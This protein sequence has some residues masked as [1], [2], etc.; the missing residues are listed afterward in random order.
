MTSLL[1]R[2]VAS[3]RLHSDIYFLNLQVGFHKNICWIGLWYKRERGTVLSKQMDLNY[4]ESNR[5][6]VE[7]I[8]TFFHHL[9][10]LLPHL[11]EL[12]I[13]QLRSNIFPNYDNCTWQQS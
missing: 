3:S 10:G 1:R 8:S 11:D 4:C 13:S 7:L 9:I 5:C 6:L 12:Y 2:L